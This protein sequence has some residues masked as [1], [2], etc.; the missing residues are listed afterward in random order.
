MRKDL[1]FLEFHRMLTAPSTN[2]IILPLQ[3]TIVD[4]NVVIRPH[5][6][7]LAVVN[8][9]EDAAVIAEVVQR[10]I[11]IDGAIGWHPVNSGF[12][13]VGVWIRILEGASLNDS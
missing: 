1:F 3:L 4:Y 5:F 13:F 2:S 8:K 7:S 11:P 6:D 10:R 9:F 12:V